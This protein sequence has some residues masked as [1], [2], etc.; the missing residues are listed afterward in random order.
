MFANFLYFLVAL[1]IYT[2]AGLFEDKASFQGGVGLSSFLVNMAFVLICRQVFRY[3]DSKRAQM[4]YGVLDRKVNQAVSRLSVLALMVF[5]LNIYGFR[6]HLY[7]RGI[8]VFDHVP[9]LGAIVFLSLFLFYL[10]VIWEASYQVQKELFAGQVTKRQYIVSNISFSLPA[11]MP[12]FFLS[13][14][15]D[16]LMLLPWEWPRLFLSTPAGEL[17]YIAF[18]IVVIAIF[19]PVLIK[20][21]WRCA[22]LEKG[23]ARDLI[24]AVCKKAD[25][26]YADILRWDLFGG[27]MITAG[28]MGL[29]G[30]FRYILV[31]PALL[32]SLDREQ[33]EAV[34]LHEIG[35]V[36]K[37]HMLFYLLF[38][39][40]F[41]ICSFLFFEPVLLLLHIL[42]VTGLFRF[43]GI[44]Q[45]T[46]A[47]IL[48]SLTL[49]GFFI[50]YFRFVFGLFMRN[51]ERQADLH[52]YRFSPD[53]APLIATFYKI[54]AYSRQSMENPN[55]HHF[56]IGQRVRFLEKCQAVPAL[57]KAHHTKVKKMIVLY[58]AAVLVVSL[59]GYSLNF[60]WAK[61]PFH[62][63]ILMQ[64]L[65]LHPDSSDVYAYVGDYFY[66]RE[67]FQKAI[68]A[69]ENVLRIDPD[70][71][72]SLN[73]L[74]MLFSTCPD[75]AFKDK[76]MALA[77]AK[78]ALELKQEAFVWDTYAEALYLNNDLSNA[79][80]AAKQAAKLANDREDFY[81]SQVERFEKLLNRK[82]SQADG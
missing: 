55:W 75:D 40:G 79:L 67:S 60:G 2:S 54:A 37:G 36:Q 56:S 42:P 30:R 44:H 1:V 57:I 27:N 70:N 17:T 63:F 35:H 71:V 20:R 82:K 76:N 47:P 43:L 21:L 26:A 68:D 48:G 3:L 58:F 78:R 29:A 13:V 80:A 77:L 19:G 6:L 23:G 14:F 73:N 51:F 52:V 28:V 9:T 34:M 22:P 8:P 24:E 11:L 10:V 59:G 18:F 62:E 64:Q 15:A 61:E 5:A 39:V 50:L 12:W 7:L 45:D 53:A 81:K 46:A 4:P 72:H 25:L 69:Y 66:H 74:S 49:I 31:T 41:I 16:I 33:L 38:F 65:K 32:N